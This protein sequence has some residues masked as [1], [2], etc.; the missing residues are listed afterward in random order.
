MGLPW[1]LFTKI[2]FCPRNHQLSI[3]HP[4]FPPVMRNSPHF[5]AVPPL[6]PTVED[7]A[8]DP[9]TPHLHR[10]TNAI[11]CHLPST[12]LLRGEGQQTH[13]GDGEISSLNLLVC[14]LSPSH[15][16]PTPLSHSPCHRCLPLAQAGQEFQILDFPEKNKGIQGLARAAFP[17]SSEKSPQSRKSQ[18]RSKVSP[19]P[20]TTRELSIESL[21]DFLSR[22]F[23]FLHMEGSPWIPGW[24]T[25]GGI[26]SPSE[27]P[28]WPQTKEILLSLREVQ[29]HHLLPFFSW[30]SFVSLWSSGSGISLGIKDTPGTKNIQQ[31]AKPCSHDSLGLHFALLMRPGKN[32]L[33]KSTHPSILD[34]SGIFFSHGT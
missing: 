8:H 16:T 10:V 27:F 21:P 2:G 15:S 11:P 30:D 12:R 7:R 31:E 24:M 26:P 20:W 9:T 23:G 25:W 32:S 19:S 17:S 3:D 18:S 34:S 5:G 6:H 1:I 29:G 13:G 33:A 4:R 22:S 14:P 28:W